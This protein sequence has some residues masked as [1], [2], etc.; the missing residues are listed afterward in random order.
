MRT[1]IDSGKTEFTYP[2]AAVAGIAYSLDRAA[3]RN[4]GDTL[5]FSTILFTAFVFGPISGAIILFVFG[6]LVYWTSKRLG[7]NASSDAIKSAIAWST[8][9]IIWGIL[10]WIPE[11]A[12]F[13]KEIFM[14]FTPTMDEKPLL[15][16]G[17]ALIETVIGIWAFIISLKCVGEVSGF[18]A[19]RAFASMLA[20]SLIIVIPVS[21]FFVL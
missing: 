7:G 14:S 1:I 6:A 9:P 17:L 15:A 16:F 19:W 2:L 12:L 3:M 10:L 18:S 4:F 5:E 13:G 20:A 21:L 11:Y 8:I